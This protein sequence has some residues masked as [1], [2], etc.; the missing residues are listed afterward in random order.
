VTLPGGI[1]GAVNSA[2]DTA[3]AF[4]LAQ[5]GKPYQ[6]GGTGPSSFDCSGLTQ[7][8]YKAA[9]IS[10]PR[11]ALL[12]SH[13]G[14]A[15]GGFSQALPGDLIFPFVDESHVCM[16]LGN[17]QIVEA[18]Q[19]GEDVHV[20]PYY[21]SAGGIRRFVAGGGSAV[22]AGLS[23]NGSNSNPASGISTTSATVFT[24]L[25]NIS[26]S[27]TSSADWASFAYLVGGAGLLFIFGVMLLGGEFL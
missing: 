10:I 26:K 21:A 7:Q 19:T 2:A 8:A 17:N 22:I 27:L 12:Q 25:G 4:A 6:W 13:S 5:V 24:Q 16:Y 9:G 20:I 1:G 23:G 11:T 18:P 15:V 14:T 3:I